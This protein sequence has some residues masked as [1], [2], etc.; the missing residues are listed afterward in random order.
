MGR[1][2][3]SVG[4]DQM[5]CRYRKQA[6]EPCIKVKIEHLNNRPSLRTFVKNFSI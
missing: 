3:G 1:I 6:N 2:Q 5:I 4:C